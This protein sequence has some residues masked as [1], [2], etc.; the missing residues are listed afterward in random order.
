MRKNI[1]ALIKQPGFTK[2]EKD[3]LRKG[4]VGNGCP[5]RSS[6]LNP[7]TTIFNLYGQEE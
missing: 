7:F 1:N 2:P 3:G 6:I 4:K 5:K